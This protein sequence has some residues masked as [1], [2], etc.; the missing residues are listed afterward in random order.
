M[1]LREK[2][3]W[4]MLYETAA[5]ANEILALNIEDLDLA[6]RRARIIS[7]G[8][9]AEYV[10]WAGGTAHLLA[11]LIRG[12]ERGPLPVP[13]PPGPCPP[14]GSQRPVPPHRPGP[15]RLR[16]RPGTAETLHLSRPRP[17]RLGPAPTPPLRRHPPRRGQHRPATDQAQGPL[18]QP[19]HR[20]CAT[21]NRVVKRSPKSPNYSMSLPGAE[22]RSPMTVAPIVQ[23]ARRYIWRP[24]ALGAEGQHWSAGQCPWYTG[25]DL[26]FATRRRK[27]G[28][29][30][31]ESPRGGANVTASPLTRDPALDDPRPP[32]P[33][34]PPASADAPHCGLVIF[35]EDDHPEGPLPPPDPSLAWRDGHPARSVLAIRG[36]TPRASHE[37]WQLVPFHKT[38]QG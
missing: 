23:I 18:A 38:L 17:A 26:G 6:V 28:A 20:K 15:P 22:E 14:T 10:Y 31:R 33:P 16:P 37:C 11:R 12:R 30:N 5:R 21:S 36:L 1:P 25:N 4:R 7:K 19:P 3:L 13:T 8:G 32:R 24:V 35:W 27:R 9:A 2:T 29:L 34:R